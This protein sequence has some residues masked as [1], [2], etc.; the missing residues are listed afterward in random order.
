MAFLGNETSCPG[1]AV[2]TSET[3]RTFFLGSLGS[4]GQLCRALRSTVGEEHRLPDFRHPFPSPDWVTTS[5]LNLSCYNPKMGIRMLYPLLRHWAD[6]L[7][8]LWW[9]PTVREVGSTSLGVVGR[10]YQIRGPVGTGWEKHLWTVMSSP[11]N[12]LN[13]VVLKTNPN[14]CSVGHLALCRHL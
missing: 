8:N 10:E 3:P 4:L 5:S 2:M 6:Y 12:L 7:Q 14:A 9:F 1:L 11:S 13:G